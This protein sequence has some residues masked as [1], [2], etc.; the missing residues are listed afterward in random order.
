LSA[1]SIL[2]ITF[3]IGF[4]NLN[5]E[6]NYAAIAQS[7]TNPISSTVK[8]DNIT[9]ATINCTNS[10]MENNKKVENIVVKNGEE[11]VVTCE[12]NPTTGYQLV[13][14]FNKD[15][16]ILLNQKF[17][18]PS[19]SI[20]MGQPGKDVFTFKAIKHGSDT[21]KIVKKRPWEKA[22]VDQKIYSVNVE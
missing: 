10:Q 13:P 3:I 12:S 14:E 20:M 22:F 19:S 16:I 5:I 17:Q 18:A 4:L 2:F 8:S 7:K 6:K 21:L 11:F 1:F 15:I 9:V